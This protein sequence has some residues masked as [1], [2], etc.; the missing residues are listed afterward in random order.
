MADFIFNNVKG[1]IKTLVSL[2]A[3]NDALIVVLVEATGVEADDTLN[4]ADDL[5]A[6]FAGAT[7]EQT[8]QSRKVVTSS[9]TVT[10]DDTNNRTDV[11]VPDQVYTALG[12]NAISD[13]IFAYDGD[14][15]GGTDA[16]IRPISMH[17]FPITPDSS[18]VTLQVAAAGLLQFS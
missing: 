3:A 4:N 10:V 8:N 11:D 18:D 12:G 9:I 17:D 14:T 6:V 15:T 13:A 5:A 1:E 2:P 16:N 7:N